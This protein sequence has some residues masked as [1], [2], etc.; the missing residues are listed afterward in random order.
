[1]PKPARRKKTMSIKI[2]KGVPLE[3]KGRG[4]GKWQQV[5]REMEI[6]DSFVVIDHQPNDYKS[7]MRASNSAKTSI[8]SAAKFAGVKIATRSLEDGHGFRVWLI[9]TEV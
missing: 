1:M 5:F 3:G 7:A 2:E 4:K 9:P 6:G 8:R